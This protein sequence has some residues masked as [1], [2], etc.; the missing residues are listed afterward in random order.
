MKK[1]IVLI[2]FILLS[3]TAQAT[4]ENFYDKLLI[5]ISGGPGLVLATGYLPDPAV[6]GT[7][8]TTYVGP[9]G[10]VGVCGGYNFYKAT[11][12]QYEHSIYA[13]VGNEFTFKNL[14]VDF[15]FPQGNGKVTYRTSF[16][17]FLGFIRG[18]LG[19][20]YYEAG[21]FYGIE[22]FEWRY[23]YH[24]VHYADANR[25][26]YGAESQNEFGMLIGFGAAFPVYKGLTID[27]GM[28]YQF[29]FTSIIE[30]NTP[31]ADV[32]AITILFKVGATYRFQ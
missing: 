22:T 8:S 17:N 23:H 11:V 10:V 28:Q 18:T 19:W 13:M 3:Y 16:F 15:E 2:L 31:D 5:G 24:G 6:H 26:V 30:S 14:V 12:S 1:I 20:F 29:G 7:Q 9:G 27:V 4:A 25:K 21:Y 32:R